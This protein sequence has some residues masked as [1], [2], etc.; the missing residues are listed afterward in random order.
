MSK[1][2]RQRAVV[3]DSA[4]V[5]MLEES[6]N[7]PSGCLFHHR[8]LATEQVDLASVRWT[9]FTYWNAVR[10]TFPAAWGLSPRESRL[11]HGAGIRSMGRLMDRVI[12]GAQSQT[13]AAAKQVRTDLRQ[14]QS[15]CRWTAGVWEDLGLAWNDIQNTPSHIRRLSDVL[16]R[17]Y[18]S[19]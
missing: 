12:G 7:S 2:A 9:L 10:D 13:A 5:R 1:Q 19:R 11:M 18:L 4:V 15:V 14:V 17:R 8:N 16:L 6:L 3:S